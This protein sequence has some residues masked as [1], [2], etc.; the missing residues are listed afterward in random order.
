M[1]RHVLGSV[2]SGTR[3]SGLSASTRSS[4]IVRLDYKP[5]IQSNCPK[6]QNIFTVLLKKHWQLP[7]T[8]N[9]VQVCHPI[10]KPKTR[11][12]LVLPTKTNLRMCSKES[13]CKAPRKTRAF[14]CVK[15]LK[16]REFYINMPAES[17]SENRFRYKPVEYPTLEFAM[18]VGCIQF[19]FG[20]VS[21]NKQHIIGT[22]DYFFIICF[23]YSHP[24]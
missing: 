24:P 16:K 13:K 7:C 17:T 5:K 8:I 2:D 1:K 19:I 22:R 14:H 18:S 3:G 10:L 21:E 20:T 11:S 15:I 23:L 4:V 9:R 6:Y 12:R